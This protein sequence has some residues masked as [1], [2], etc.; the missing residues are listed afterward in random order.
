MARQ[1][2]KPFER[3]GTYILF[4]RIDTDSFGELWRVGAIEGKE[5]GGLLALRK[6][7]G[8]KTTMAGAVAAASPLVG[9]VEGAAL[10]RGQSYGVVNGEPFITWEYGGGRSLRH[11]V[12]RARE[13]GH[14]PIPTDQA[15]AI[16]EKVASALEYV[17]TVKVDGRRILH[18]S[19]IPQFIWIYDD[20]DVRVAGQYLNAGLLSSLPDPAVAAEIGPYVAPEIRG[21]GAPT[22]ATDVYSIGAVLYLMVTGQEPPDSASGSVTEALSSATLMQSGEALPPDLH[23]ILETAMNTDPA[24]RYP[25][26][27]DLKQAITDVL[28]SGNYSPTTFNLAFYLHNLLR[29]EMEGESVEREKESKVNPEP[30]IEEIEE[31]KAEAAAP[32]PAAP[33]PAPAPPPEPAPPPPEPAA[34]PQAPSPLSAPAFSGSLDMGSEKSKAPLIATAFFLVATGAASVWYVTKGRTAEPVPQVA[35][36]EPS[37]PVAAPEPEPVEELPLE[38][39]VVTEIPGAEEEVPVDDAEAARK[40]AMEAEVNRRVQEEMRKLQDDYNRQIKQQQQAEA[41]AETPPPSKPQPKPAEPAPSTAAKPD[42]P[43]ASTPDTSATTTAA[44]EPP[45]ATET[46]T[47]AEQA[48][49]PPAPPPPAPVAVREGDLVVSSEVD[50]LPTILKR[51][52]PVYPPIAAKQKIS[53][54]VIVSALVDESGKV[55]DAK[56]LRGD[57][58]NLGFDDASLKA[59]RKFTFQPA[60]KDGKKVKTWYSVPFIFGEQQ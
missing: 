50:S 56:V 21:G 27:G 37:A 16:G 32:R 46:E 31:E 9:T 33:P 58:R 23:R 60:T 44:V 39:P 10:V 2:S 59:I 20:G 28:S 17:S 41:A 19:L 14:A 1:R 7:T 47:V 24:A 49:P 43:A 29:K 12:D 26:P 30:Y 57:N 38:E 40:K 11:L 35:Q 34:E 52:A 42:E 4:K 6:L 25:S 5:V 48:T 55:I 18:G 8:D 3:F 45:A 22:R 53:S 15:L 13:G 54:F 51:V 36:A